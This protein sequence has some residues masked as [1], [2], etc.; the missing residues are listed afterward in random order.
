[1]P[2]G[3]AGLAQD[4]ETAVLLNQGHY[5]GLAAWWSSRSKFA[6]L[7]ASVILAP[8]ANPIMQYA[9]T[10]SRRIVGDWP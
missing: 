7:G 4:Q 1:M 6:I 3:H 5:A 9:R 2:I 8:N 10:I